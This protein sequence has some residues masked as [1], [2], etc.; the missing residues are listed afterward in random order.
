MQYNFKKCMGQKGLIITTLSI[1]IMTLQQAMTKL[2]TNHDV[3]SKSRENNNYALWHNVLDAS[4]DFILLTS[5]F[6][7]FTCKIS[8]T[9]VDLIFRSVITPFFI[10][11][12]YHVKNFF[13]QSHKVNHFNLS[14]I[15]FII[16]IFSIL[17]ILW[18]FA[19]TAVY[20]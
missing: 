1:Y 12:K 10:L 16:N 2:S 9:K 15:Y 3:Y 6:E 11:R 13:G 5:K 7:K 17:L 18:R 4:I 14:M 19:Y 20:S 8:K